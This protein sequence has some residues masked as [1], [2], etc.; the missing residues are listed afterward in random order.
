MV[1]TGCLPL[2]FCELLAFRSP[3]AYRIMSVKWF[4]HGSTRP[5]TNWNFSS[6]YSQHP[7]GS[8]DLS[9]PW[10]FY[11]IGSALIWF[12]LR[13]TGRLQVVGLDNVPSDGAVLVANHVGWLDPLWIGAAIAPRPLFFMAKRELFIPILRKLLPSMGVFPIDRAN[14]GPSSLKKSMH[15]LRRRGIVV[16]FPTGTRSD[17]VALVKRGAATIA[18]LAD[19]PILPA[20]YEGPASLTLSAFWQR[21]R[22]TVR[23]L[24]VLWPNRLEANSTKVEI[25]MI[26]SSLKQLLEDNPDDP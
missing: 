12:V 2:E 26:S 5:T 6:M 11:R 25:R 16:I 18:T 10:T 13:L 4:S 19:C 17:R 23:F 22:V 21:P 3:R 8:A 20:I 9:R 1:A 14:P 15:I 7:I 24:P